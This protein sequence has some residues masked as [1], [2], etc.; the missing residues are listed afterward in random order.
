M[1]RCLYLLL[2]LL[3]VLPLEV[4]ARKP[5]L[6]AGGDPSDSLMIAAITR[7]AAQF[8]PEQADSAITCYQ[9][10]IQL[11]LHLQHSNGLAIAVNNLSATFER[12][13]AYEQALT[14][15]SYVLARARLSPRLQGALPIIYNCMGNI[16]KSC[17]RLEDAA[18]SYHQAVS[19]ME[20]GTEGHY[21]SIYNNLASVLIHIEHHDQAL[22]YL[23]KAETV[24]MQ[25]HHY[26]ALGMAVLNKGLVYLL[27]ED[28]PTAQQY[29]LRALDLAR[30]HRLVQVEHLTLTNLGELYCRQEMP[31]RAL[32]YLL[33]QNNIKGSVF[34]Y[35]RIAGYELTGRVY[36]M[37]GDDRRAEAWFLRAMDSAGKMHTNDRLMNIHNSLATFY[38]E[39]G[40]HRKSLAHMEALVRLKDSLDN[41]EI[42]KNMDLLD[43][44]YRSSEQQKEIIRKK[45]QISSQENKLRN[46]NIW[47]TGISITA[48]FGCILFMGIYSLNKNK[49]RLQAKQ[50]QLLEQQ[51]DL[52]QKESEIK[53]LKA[54]MQGEDNE[55]TRIAGDLHDGIGG[56][57]ATIRMNVK[58]LYGLPPEEQRAQLDQLVQMIDDTA[59][60]VRDTAHNLMPGTLLRYG[61]TGTL[62]QYG[63][64]VNRSGQLRVDMQ[65]Y[66]ALDELEAPVALSV[67]RI[68]QELLQNIVRHA[69]ASTAAIQVRRT[70]DLVNIVAEDNGTGF[71]AV[72]ERGSGLKQLDLRVRALQGEL[73]ID[74]SA[75]QGTTVYIELN[76]AA[77]QHS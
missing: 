70:G 4:A 74:S 71:D 32:Q 45:L 23:N 30:R 39:Q 37:L 10:A 35:Y 26:E 22:Y 57:L 29:L 77:L 33:Q 46:K 36:S 17:G 64:Q 60:E 2:L 18:K 75:A 27:R 72:R 13:G 66:G 38:K 8:P 55:R 31:E 53:T 11:A 44:K 68:V 50:I 1:K 16:Y 42:K 43:V 63:D 76:A 52:L 59:S 12:T 19:A 15:F 21:A 6:V 58:A 67:Y 47:I 48:L 51:Q 73:L 34:P 49:Q 5:L 62:Q 56:M 24:G 61:L 3:Q 40:D 69:Q 14:T 41:S 20:K 28:W 9:L 65:L 7:R 25:S 54:M